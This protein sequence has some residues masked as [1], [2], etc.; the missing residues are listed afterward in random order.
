MQAQREYDA[1]AGQ[2]LLYQGTFFKYIF[3]LSFNINLNKQN[4]W[5]LEDLGVILFTYIFILSLYSYPKFL[6]G[7]NFTFEDDY[8]SG[9]EGDE[10]DVDHMTYEVRKNN[11]NNN[12]V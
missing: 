9:D 6:G 4:W 10:E 3:P 12:K 5:Q 2:Q 11:N 1:E 7:R 8:D